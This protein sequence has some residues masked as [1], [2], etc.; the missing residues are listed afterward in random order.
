MRRL[1]KLPPHF[2]DGYDRKSLVAAL[3]LALLYL[4]IGFLWS[5]LLRQNQADI[6]WRLITLWAGMTALVCWRVQ[7]RHDLALAAVALA[8]GFAFEWWGTHAQLWHYFTGEQPPL[9]ILPAWPVAALATKRLAPLLETVCSKAPL[10]WK[11]V[12]WTLMLLFAAGMIR[13]LWPSLRHWSSQV[14]TAAIL[15]VIATGKA[16]RRDLGLLLAGT[17]LGFLLEYWGTSHQ[18]WT[19]YTAQTPPPITAAAHGFAQVCYARLLDASAR[20]LHLN[21]QPLPCSGSDRG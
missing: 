16:H 10:S 4:A 15:I 13:F 11:A 19:Y 9:W 21:P 5:E 20:L 6:T 14:A 18:C 2:L 8:G 3:I 7:P 12:Y 17:G 1:L